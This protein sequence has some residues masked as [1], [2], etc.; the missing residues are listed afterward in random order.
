MMTERYDAEQKIKPFCPPWYGQFIL[1][2]KS[3]QQ[4]SRLPHAILLSLPRESDEVAFIWYLSMSLLCQ[5]NEDGHPCCQCLSCNHML[6]N[7]YPDFQIVSLLY[8]NSKRKYNKNI[9][10]EQIRELI[11]D[12]YITRSYDNLKIAVIYP[13]DRMS[14]AGANS[15]LKTL[16]EPAE[17]ALIIIATHNP[18]KIP[19]TIRSRCQQWSMPLPNR[20]E[21]VNWL[22]NAGF[23]S[24]E[25]CTQYLDYSDGNPGLAIKLFEASYSGLVSEFK[26]KFSQ[27]LKNQI[28]AV[29]LAQ[30]LTGMEVVLAR[31][32]I[33]M[34]AKAYCFRYCGLNETPARKVAARPML[35]LMAQ[36]EYQLIIEENNL[37]LQLQLIDVLISI[38][39]IIIKNQQS[40][41]SWE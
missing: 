39:Q 32:L 21:A 22:E 24:K 35:D 4:Q 34:V 3:L 10:I 25:Q 9:K 20:D 12:V 18:G 30:F 33:S 37:D 27:Y 14:I 31:R 15:L 5:N 7:T 26:E 19:V 41:R 1:K 8:D 40:T 11:H 23:D 29:M 38:K 13:A 16:E 28:D 36:I 17:N 2:M 6:A